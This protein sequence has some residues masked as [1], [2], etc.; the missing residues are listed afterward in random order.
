MSTDG[1]FLLLI[2]LFDSSPAFGQRHVRELIKHCMF[3]FI[4]FITPR[5]AR[6]TT[7][8]WTLKISVL[9]SSGVCAFGFFFIFWRWKGV[10]GVWGSRR[11]IEHGFPGSSPPSPTSHWSF[12]GSIKFVLVEIGML[13]VRAR[14][15]VLSPET[16]PCLD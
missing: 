9:Y 11:P 6:C 4:Y 16:A 7:V 14:G 1:I 3:L 13:S 15:P 5:S 12:P 8:Y 10:W 2:P